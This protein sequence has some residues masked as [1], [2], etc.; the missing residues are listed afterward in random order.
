MTQF[1]EWIQDY[2][3]AITNFEVKTMFQ[4]MIRG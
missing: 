2:E 4:G 1:G 3:L